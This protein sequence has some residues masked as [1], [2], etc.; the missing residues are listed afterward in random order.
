MPNLL[1]DPADIRRWAE[2]AGYDVR[3]TA[4]L[5]VDDMKR[6]AAAGEPEAATI[7]ADWTLAGCIQRIKRVIVASDSVAVPS[8]PS[9]PARMSIRTDDGSRQL[10]AWEFMTRADFEKVVRDY[11][12]QALR[13]QRVMRTFRQVL[14]TWDTHP[15]AA[16]AAEAMRLAGI[17]PEAVKVAA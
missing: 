13:R 5:A 9:L 3:R 2:E 7:L 1:T 17:D 11:A 4:S 16:N 8:R 14:A 12:A 6:R 15:E 10:V